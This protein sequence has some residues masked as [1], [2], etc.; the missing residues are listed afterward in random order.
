MTQLSHNNTGGSSTLINFNCR[1]SDAG[2]M[3]IL[4]GG[5]CGHQKGGWKPF[6]DWKQTDRAKL[7]CAMRDPHRVRGYT[8][9]KSCFIKR[10]IQKL[11]SKSFEEKSIQQP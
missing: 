11:D 4:R 2:Q 3:L 6:G 7:E 10:L 9:Y 5:V 8:Y 1:N